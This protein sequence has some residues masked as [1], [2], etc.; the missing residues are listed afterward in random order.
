MRKGE[1][2]QITL[3]SKAL[4][5]IEHRLTSKS[6]TVQYFVHLADTTKV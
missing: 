1:Y 4:S 3:K 2:S 6:A 5:G